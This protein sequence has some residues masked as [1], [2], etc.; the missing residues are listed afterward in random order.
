[1]QEN[2]LPVWLPFLFPFF[3]VGMWLFA[4]TM[5]GVLSGWNA[6]RE[7]FP[8]RDATNLLR[9]GWQSGRMGKVMGGA[10]FGGCLTLTATP[11]GLRVAIWRLFGSFQSPFLVPWD[12]I[13]PEPVRELFAP[14]IRLHF[15]DTGRLTIAARVWERLAGQVAPGITAPVPPVSRKRNA[16]AFLLQWILIT[17]FFGFFIV[18][19]PRLLNVAEPAP[20]AILAFPAV[21]FGIAQLIRFRL[22]G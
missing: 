7:R 9:L 15:G 5:I 19:L 6:L 1:M 16:G 13:R 8:D 21:F 20:L 14:A 22:E 3:F 2:E 12:R 18:G 11:L 10:S 17:A 4:T